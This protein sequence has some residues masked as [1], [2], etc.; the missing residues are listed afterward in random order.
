MNTVSPNFDPDATV[1]I[2]TVGQR[3]FRRYELVSLVGRG[4][5]GVV[6]KAM[7]RR[8]NR[9]VALKFLPEIFALDEESVGELRRET[10]RSLE[11]THPNIVRVHDFLHEGNAAAISMELVNGASLVSL[12][13][14]ETCHVLT[15]AQLEPLVRQVC[16]A[17]DYAHRDAKIVHRDLKPANVM[18]TDIGRVKILDFGISASISETAS[19]ITNRG[20]SG[21][22][23]YMSP[24]QLRGKAPSAADDWYALGALLYDVLTGKPP[25]FRGDVPMQIL[26]APPEALHVRREEFGVLGEPIPE[27]WSMTIAGLLAKEPEQ[28]IRSGEEV[29]ASLAGRNSTSVSAV[30]IAEKESQQAPLPVKANPVSR[31]RT[32]LWAILQVFAVM[33]LGGA[34]YFA[35]IVPEEKTRVAHERQQTEATEMARVLEKARLAAAEKARG[36]AIVRTTPSGANVT[37]GAL[38]TERSPLTLREEKLGTYPVKVRLEGYEPFDANIEVKQNEFSELDVVLKRTV[39]ALQL[40]SEPKGVDFELREG[41]ELVHGTTPKIIDNVPT[42]RVEIVMRRPGWPELKK[43]VN[44]IRQ[45]TSIVRE[46][47]PTGKVEIVTDPSGAKVEANDK[48]VLGQTPLILNEI[49]PGVVN[50]RVT[51]S[52]FEPVILKGEVEGRKTLELKTALKPKKWPVKEGQSFLIPGLGLEFVGIV[53]GK[54]IMGS[55]EGSVDEKPEHSVTLTRPYW[56]GKYDVTLAEWKNLMET[57]P[58]RFK[59]ERLPVE[60]VSYGDAMEFCRRL[61]ERE[62]AANRLPLDYAYTL[63]TEAQW[64]YAC[65]AGTKGDYAGDLDAMGWYDKISSNTTH[66]VGQKQPNAWGLYDM[67][68][69]V[70]Q[71]CLDGFESYTAAAV[72]DPVGSASSARRAVR[73]GA[74]SLSPYS[75]RSVSRAGVNPSAHY[76][77]LGFRVALNPM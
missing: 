56:I 45:E 25:F 63:P 30:Q 46:E 47:F 14:R 42:G 73:G 12:K 67:H 38:P 16:A 53:P 40:E 74:W 44:V 58:N 52:G 11:L 36:G 50:Y 55:K 22:L 9:V 31:K 3:V 41:E 20:T 32:A 70:R 6:W 7:D 4:G 18:V 76:D 19:R 72:N 28:R 26:N 65:R 39:G 71:W 48:T 35:K 57:D 5:M 51:L 54:F 37:F 69:N 33:A 10:T 64:E 29:L 27:N 15:V 62:R 75:C 66:P 23:N 24:Q 8:L 21:T 17:L 1:R 61:T 49:V 2:F 60:N 34:Y 59:G 77:N 43:Q 13:Q 68:G